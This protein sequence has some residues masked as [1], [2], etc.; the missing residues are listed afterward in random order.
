LGLI[1]LW[2]FYFAIFLYDLKERKKVKDRED[3]PHQERNKSQGIDLP[4]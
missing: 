4:A 2:E 3:V 1:Y